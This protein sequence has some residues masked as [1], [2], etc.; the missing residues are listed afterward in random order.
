M[1]LSWFLGNATVADLCEKCPETLSN[2]CIQL[3]DRRFV[4]NWYHLGLK[5]GIDGKQLQKLQ[6]SSE[7]SPAEEVLNTIYT[8]APDLLLT[9]M[10]DDLKTLNL[11]AGIEGTIANA[12]GKFEG[13]KQNFQSQVT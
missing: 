12:L 2:I 13:K 8:L 9:D 11:V 10:K 5:I 1:F 7:N 6:D 3:D 4:Q